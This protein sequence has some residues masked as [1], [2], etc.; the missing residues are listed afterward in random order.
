MAPIVPIFFI[1]VDGVLNPFAAET[2]PAGFQ[3]HELFPGEEPVRVCLDHGGWL[4]ELA[5]RF[6]LVWASAWGDKAN[7]LLAP[8]LGLPE[9]PFVEFPPVPFSPLDKVPAVARFVGPRPAV[10][11]DDALTA[12]ARAWA[13]S[14][15]APTL[16]V[17]INPA[18]GLTRDTV[19]RCLLWAA[20]GI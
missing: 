5:D 1:D 19:D 18:E 11:I 3:E 6:E 4:R 8:L 10:W 9:L 7:R 15:E 20:D 17:D 14:R 16:L 12:E 2:C 13:A